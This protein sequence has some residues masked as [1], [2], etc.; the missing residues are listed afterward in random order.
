MWIYFAI[1]HAFAL[2]KLPGNLQALVASPAQQDYDRFCAPTLQELDQLEASVGKISKDNLK[3]YSS[4]NLNLGYVVGA[5]A[6]I[7]TEFGS[8]LQSKQKEGVDRLYTVFI[9]K[10]ELID[11]YGNGGAFDALSQNIFTRDVP[12]D[13]SHFLCTPERV[14]IVDGFIA[15][16]WLTSELKTLEETVH[17]VTPLVEF[18]NQLNGVY[19]SYVAIAKAKSNDCLASKLEQVY[20]Y[21]N[22][23]PESIRK[24]WEA[25][26]RQEVAN[27][28]KVE[29][30]R[31]VYPYAQFKRITETK[32]EISSDGTVRV[33]RMDY[34]VMDA[35]VY[36]VN[37]EFVDGYI[38]SLY[39]DHIQNAEYARFYGLDA[40]GQLRPSQRL[41]KSNF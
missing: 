17:G 25:T 14:D 2:P 10:H 1:A 22:A 23:A 38:V 34:D 3:E 19:D 40:N 32:R 9:R 21:S 37:G 27:N 5:C 4:A 12:L 30:A 13:S 28:A 29:I 16:S 11:L 35:Y 39:K 33:N 8:P 18:E 15:K 41:L 20:P 7:Q 31:I 6:N 36:V 26:I 24:E